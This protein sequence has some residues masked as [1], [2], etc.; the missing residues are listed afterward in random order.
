MHT[1]KTVTAVLAGLAVVA[2]FFAELPKAQAEEFVRWGSVAFSP[3]TGK[4][5]WSRG[6]LDQGNADRVAKKNCGVDDAKIIAQGGNVWVALATGEGT[7]YGV[8]LHADADRA[9][10]IALEHCGKRSDNCKIV[11]LYHSQLSY[12][13]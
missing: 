5:G 1:N 13:P 3:S 2:G 6:W 4:W 9:K 10:E 11:L 8:G 12:N 7:T